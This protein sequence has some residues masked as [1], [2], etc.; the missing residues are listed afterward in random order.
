MGRNSVTYIIYR[1]QKLCDRLNATVT[2]D[3]VSTTTWKMNECIVSKLQDKYQR[4]LP[5]ATLQEIEYELIEVIKRYNRYSRNPRLIVIF[6][7]LDK[8]ATAQEEDKNDISTDYEKLSSRPGQ[9]ISSRKRKEQ[10]LALIANLKYF[11]STA[12]AT[13]V[14]IAGREM[15]ESFQ[16]DMSDRDF[17]ISSIFNGILNIDSFLYSNIE[18]N[19]VTLQ[20]ERFVCSQ[21]L[22]ENF[23][24]QLSGA[25]MAYVF[26]KKPSLKNYLL[27]RIYCRND[28]YEGESQD[29]RHQRIWDEVLFL[30]HFIHYLTFISNGS[31]KK[32]TLFFEKYI[33]N[34]TYLEEE[35]QVRFPQDAV[36]EKV[37]SAQRF[38]LSF[39]YYS[40]TKIN[41]IHYLLQPILTGILNDSNQFGDKLLVSASFLV[42]Y[43]FKL[44]NNGFSWRNLE[45]MPEIQE[46][47]RTPEIR[48]YLG[49]V[50]NFMN[51]S[52]LVTNPCS[53]YHYK[54]PMKIV[55]EISFHSK[56]SSEVSSLFN[57]ASDEFLPIKNKYKR[58][59]RK[60][61]ETEGGNHHSVYAKAS[62]HHSLGDILMLEENYSGA[63]REYEYCVE[64][65]QPIFAVTDGAKKIEA[66]TQQLNYLMFLNRSILKLGLAHEKRRTDNSAFM[67]YQEMIKTLKRTAPHFELKKDDF[68]N[69]TAL[70]QNN[71]MIHLSLLAQLYT[72]EKLDT[73]GITSYH[74][75]DV[76]NN[77]KS[78]FSKKLRTLNPLLSA[79]FYRKLRDILYY[80][81]QS[82]ENNWKNYTAFLFYRK[83][84]CL[85]LDIPYT[86]SDNQF[87]KK[88]WKN[89]NILSQEKN[90]QEERDNV[91]YYEALI[92][93]SIAHTYLAHSNDEFSRCHLSPQ[94]F[95][96][97]LYCWMRQPPQDKE[98]SQ[99]TKFQLTQIFS[100]I[101][102]HCQLERA[103]I[104]YG[105][106]SHLYNRSCERN[107][108][109]RCYKSMVY[110][111]TIYNRMTGYTDW[112][113]KLNLIK[114]TSRHA[115]ITNYRQKEFISYAEECVMREYK[116]LN[117]FNM[118]PINQ[119]SMIP[120]TES[121]LFFYYK[122]KLE[123]WLY[124]CRQVQ[125]NG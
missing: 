57:F 93:E 1:L 24:S 32:I 14:F 35:K 19:N 100:C 46:I 87:C 51:H 40:Q 64:L 97:W 59:L 123:G 8:I 31:P 17:S 30:Y 41:F 16:N 27:Y 68:H 55:E 53:L 66:G 15:Y 65:I 47:N 107:L 80:K 49:M 121:L 48:E 29:E 84:L 113:L 21:L 4:V 38:Y 76:C 115:L 67:A 103:I 73:T 82:A 102:T 52:Y 45:Q 124:S 54:F 78:I 99:V 94:R 125:A 85:L 75:K 5:P 110:S 81:N 63:I 79:D 11:L 10:V 28:W 22:P 44:H 33:R 116:Q 122:Q 83:S 96:I 88:V 109:G 12:Q 43:I 18:E 90:G 118:I 98:P 95:L 39:G 23:H 89:L 36:A 114:E 25:V 9:P 105:M 101:D 37:E 119:L 2:E 77:F 72:L 3:K 111:L 108:S 50:I 56:I 58:L 92:C 120:D 34:H 104:F 106:A 86:D 61:T 20:T 91:L 13:F 6:D 26:D 7:E 42:A 71:R 62:I 74:I 112:K 70:Y 117:L 60:Y 69:Y